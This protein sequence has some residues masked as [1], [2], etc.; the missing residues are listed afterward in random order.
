[1]GSA[2]AVYAAPHDLQTKRQEWRERETQ[3]L[4]E[5]KKERLCATEED[6]WSKRERKRREGRRG[7][8]TCCFNQ[9][10]RKEEPTLGKARG[11][12]IRQ[13]RR[14]CESYTAQRCGEKWN[15]ARATEKRRRARAKEGQRTTEKLEVQKNNGAAVSTWLAI[16]RTDINESRIETIISKTIFTTA[17]RYLLILHN[18]W[19]NSVCCSFSAYRV[20]C[21]FLPCSEGSVRRRHGTVSRL[22]RA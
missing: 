6:R 11:E 14:R 9:T 5:G 15:Q 13:T 10:K 19:H 1:M 18:N 8:K 22:R 7:R 2:A 4:K 12:E 17:I 20:V 3:R 16:F 21:M